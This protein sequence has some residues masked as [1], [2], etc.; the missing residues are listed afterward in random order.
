M[1]FFFAAERCAARNDDSV[2]VSR[3]RFI[4]PDCSLKRIDCGSGIIKPTEASVLILPLLDL[5]FLQHHAFESS[6]RTQM[7]PTSTTSPFDRHDTPPK[8]CHL[9]THMP[10]TKPASPPEPSPEP[11]LVRPETH[12]ALKPSGTPTPRVAPGR[13]S[14]L[15]YPA[16]SLLPFSFA[17]ACATPAAIRS[18]AAP[19]AVVRIR[20]FLTFA[21]VCEMAER[22]VVQHGRFLFV[23]AWGPGEEQS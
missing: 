7:M 15:A 16:Q 1:D 13:P 18:H 19:L 23:G 9:P 14:S 22:D 10:T 17:L 21:P 6:L 8:T 5:F 2:T 4:R 20:R 3:R 11:A 12:D